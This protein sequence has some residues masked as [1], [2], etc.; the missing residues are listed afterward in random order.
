M[1]KP[2]IRHAYA[3]ME[4]AVLAYRRAC[5]AE[6]EAAKRDADAAPGSIALDDH[7]RESAHRLYDAD[8]ITLPGLERAPMQ[9]R[10]RPRASALVDIVGAR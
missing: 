10:S 8:K 4:A 6:Y 3:A 2:E 1:I 5:D 7:W 9:P